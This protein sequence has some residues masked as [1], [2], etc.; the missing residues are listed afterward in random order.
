MPYACLYLNI[1]Y[2]KSK[3][4]TYRGVQILT[5][6]GKVLESVRSRDY[7]VDL[8]EASRG[9]LLLADTVLP[10]SKVEEFET[11][12]KLSPAERISLR[13]LR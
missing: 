1:D 5:A 6:S 13:G 3:P 8:V 10:T 4:G 2:D 12:L 9:A 7:K 11:D